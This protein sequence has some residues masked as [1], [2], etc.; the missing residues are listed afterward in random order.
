MN[1]DKIKTTDEFKSLTPKELKNLMLKQYPFHFK[2]K[3]SVWNLFYIG[4]VAVFGIT[5]IVIGANL[6]LDDPQM[7]FL[8]GIG[9]ALLL[10]GE[11]IVFLYVY[12]DLNQ[13]LK[14]TP[15]AITV[16]RGRKH[17]PY[18]FEKIYNIEF[19]IITIN[20]ASEKMFRIITDQGKKRE[21]SL[22][23]WITP[24]PLPSDQIIRSILQAYF[25]LAH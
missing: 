23:R 12:Q 14:I 20:G 22:Q 5:L 6:S 19:Y 3:N 16:I 24:R 13:S 15:E 8:S 7:I 18:Y 11:T 21:V 17:N 4:I 1:Q 9:V 2:R 10:I 25:T